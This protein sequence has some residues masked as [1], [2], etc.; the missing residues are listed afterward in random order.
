MFDVQL[1]SGHSNSHVLLSS[2][3]RSDFEGYTIR[4][5]D[6]EKTVVFDVRFVKKYVAFSVCFYKPVPL[7][8][9]V[10][11]YRSLSHDD[12]VLSVYTV[13]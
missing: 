6:T 2:G 11:L 3:H 8:L 5:L 7:L 1:L 9:V 13:W 4:L 12:T 10:P